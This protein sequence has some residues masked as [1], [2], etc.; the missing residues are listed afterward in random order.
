MFMQHQPEYHF[1]VVQFDKAVRKHVGSCRSLLLTDF[2]GEHLDKDSLSPCVRDTFF[3]DPIPQPSD[4]E[5]N[6]AIV[7]STILSQLFL[8]KVVTPIN[9]DTFEELLETHPNQL[10]VRSICYALRH[11][12]WPWAETTKDDYPTTVGQPN[13]APQSDVHIDFISHQFQEEEACLHFSLSFGSDLLPGMYS[14]P[15]HAVPKPRSEKLH[16]VIDHSA[17]SPSLNDMIDRNLIGGTKMEGMRSFGASLLAFRAQHPNARLVIFKFDVSMAYRHMPMHPLWQLKQVITAP[18]GNYHVDRCNNFSGRGSCK[19]WVS[20]MSLVIWIAI[21]VKL[22][23][24]LKAYVDDSYSFELVGNMKFYAPYNKLLLAKQTDLLLLWDLIGLPHNEPKQVFGETLEVIGFIVDPNVMSVLF[25]EPKCAELIAAYPRLSALYEKVAGKSNMFAGVTMNT[26]IACELG[27]IAHHLECLPRIRLF[28]AHAWTP[29]D[30]GVMSM[31]VDAATS[32]GLGVFFPHLSL[33]FQCFTS[34]LPPGAHINLLELLAVASTVHLSALMDCVP[35]R[36]A[37]YSDSTFA[38]NVFNT[39]RASPPF[40]DV[41]LTSVDTLIANNAVADALSHFHND[42]R[43]IALGMALECSSAAAYNSHLNLYLTFCCVHNRP[44]TPTVDTLSFFIVYMSAHICPDSVIVYLAGI[45]NHL[46][47]EF[48]NIWL[49]CGCLR[50]SCQQLLRKPPLDLTILHNVLSASTRSALYD[51]LLFATLM[52][53]GFY[54]LMR[55]GELVWPDAVILQ[56]SLRINR[57]SYSFTLPTHKSLRVG[58]GNDVLVRSFAAG[59]DPL[60][61]LHKYMLPGKPANSG[62]VGELFSLLKSR[63]GSRKTI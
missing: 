30:P 55:L 19:I 31:F 53:T 25:L 16:M 23:S 12:F 49:H 5:H 26:A 36:V 56:C 15:V 2:S 50:R 48:P 51:N 43:A 59:A 21:Y 8:F 9:I 37:V 10:F 4:Q 61:V 1:W 46:E 34:D 3:A 24:H 42:S 18:D 13:R 28:N 11:G 39:L 41:L 54:V 40:N 33:D 63:L 52:A 62:L 58:H 6:N 47:G 27:W 57:D 60:P 38:I 22:L 14:M 35:Q 32:G 7:R 29:S 20:F 44:V 17:G 45:C